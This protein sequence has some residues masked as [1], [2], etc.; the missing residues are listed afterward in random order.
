MSGSAKDMKASPL[1][2]AHTT[3]TKFS[4]PVS[5]LPNAS[6]PIRGKKTRSDVAPMSTGAFNKHKGQYA[7]HV[8]GK[9]RH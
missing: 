9:G 2:R 3:M 5:G 8:N 1:S 4:G 7:A 6:S